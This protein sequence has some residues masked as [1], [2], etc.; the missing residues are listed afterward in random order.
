[1][2]S[3]WVMSAITDLQFSDVTQTVQ[4]KMKSF[5]W[6]LVLS[7]LWMFILH[8]YILFR[9]LNKKQR[10]FQGTRWRILSNTFFFLL[11]KP[12]HGFISS[13]KFLLTF[14]CTH[15]HYSDLNQLEFFRIKHYL[16][17]YRLIYI[18]VCVCVCTQPLCMNR[19]PHKLYA[20][21]RSE[22]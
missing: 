18:Y 4:R 16:F 17:I 7:G 6:K 13:S 22:V 1:M 5:D 8:V 2:I 11:R 15:T 10:K 19:M 20:N 14:A 9:Q 21:T 3:V 12:F